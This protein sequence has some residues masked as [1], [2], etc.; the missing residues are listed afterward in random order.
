MAEAPTVRPKRTRRGLKS[1]TLARTGNETDTASPSDTN[2]CAQTSASHFR[3]E[4]GA[5]VIKLIGPATRSVYVAIRGEVKHKMDFAMLP[6]R[7]CPV[8]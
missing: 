8:D 2:A 6:L 4:T 7:R 1:F 5:F 3:G